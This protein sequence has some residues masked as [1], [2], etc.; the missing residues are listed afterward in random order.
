M[1]LIIFWTAR[2]DKDMTVNMSI[3]VEGNNNQSR[4]KKKKKTVFHFRQYLH[5]HHHHHHHH[6]NYCSYYIYSCFEWRWGTRERYYS[7]YLDTVYMQLDNWVRDVVRN[8]SLPMCKYCKY[9][10]VLFCTL[11]KIRRLERRRY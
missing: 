1:K 4:L 3:S 11:R 10:S 8:F 5:H 7:V 9:S 6:Y 2:V